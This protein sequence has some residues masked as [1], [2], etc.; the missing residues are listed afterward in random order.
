MGMNPMNIYLYSY[1]LRIIFSWNVSNVRWITWSE[2]TVKCKTFTA[3]FTKI[4]I[5]NWFGSF[6]CCPPS[7]QNLHSNLSQAQS[8]GIFSMCKI[9]LWGYAREPSE[10]QYESCES[11]W[12]WTHFHCNCS[13]KEFCNPCFPLNNKTKFLCSHRKSTKHLARSGHSL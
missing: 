9:T 11:K 8:S 7:T 4:T 10:I 3:Q 1:K 6:V 13:C 5:Q 12:Q 2:M